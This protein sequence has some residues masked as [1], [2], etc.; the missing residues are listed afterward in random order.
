MGFSVDALT[1][2]MLLVVTVVA[3]MVQIYSVGYMH[4]DK[5]YPRYFA[6]LSL[7]SAAMLTLVIA[8]N[9][10]LMFMSWELV[11]LTSYLLIGFWFEKPSAMRAAKKAFLVTRVGDVGFL[12]GLILLYP[13][14]RLVQPVR[15]RR[16]YSRTWTSCRGWCTSG[17]GRSR[18]RRW[19]GCCSSA[20]RS[21]S[22]AQFPLHV[23]LP[24]AMEGPT[25]VSALDPRGHD[26]RG[27]RVS[28]RE[29]VSGLSCRYEPRRAERG[30]LRRRVH[31][32]VRGDDRHRAERHQARAG[33]LDHQPA[34]LYDN[35]AGRLR[36][37]R[38]RCST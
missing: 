26:G 22:R 21:A 36:L 20:G 17:R 8:N 31:G 3:S 18:W 34:R 19:R 32:A 23:W 16:A 24:D 30:R 15:R 27:G 10:L 33:V 7:F 9:I 28:G 25:P 11:G 14:D 35:G 13:A 2:V 37:R 38:R 29:D 5:R 6:Y 12:A 1:C 4:G